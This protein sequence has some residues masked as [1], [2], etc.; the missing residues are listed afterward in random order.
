MNDNYKLLDCDR[1]TILGLPSP[2]VHLFMVYWM[3]EG[4]TGE[5]YLSLRTIKHIT[6]WKSFDTVIKWRDYLITNGWLV[7]TG[8]TA[9]ERYV[10]PTNG[11]WKVPTVRVDDPS[12][13][14][15]KIGAAPNNGA[16]APKIE[17]PK[18]WSE[19]SVSA[20]SPFT[21]TI[22]SLPVSSDNG[23]KE[24][25]KTLPAPQGKATT[26]AKAK[27]LAADVKFRE[28]YGED[29]PAWFDDFTHPSNPHK[30]KADWTKARAEWIYLRTPEGKEATARARDRGRPLPFDPPPPP[31]FKCP[32][33]DL[34]GNPCDFGCK[35]EEALINHIQEWHSEEMN[36]NEEGAYV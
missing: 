18:D 19:A 10:K 17:A 36:S 25:L 30:T 23:E 8:A 14:A 5:A 35:Y 22:S 32:H 12:K 20:Y 27:T 21:D 34:L 26:T 11:A 6:G 1:K 24:P 33:P 15:P 3:H 9:A 16:G 31:R 4:A 13:G 2:A 29:R 7:K 28:K